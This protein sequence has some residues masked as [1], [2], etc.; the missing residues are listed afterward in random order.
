[1]LRDQRRGPMP[2]L[3]RIPQAHDQEQG[4]AAAGL[5]PVDTNSVIESEWHILTVL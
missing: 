5:F 3:V 1:M 2:H 4:R